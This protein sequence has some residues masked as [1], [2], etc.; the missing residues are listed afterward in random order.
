MNLV[1][2][3]EGLDRVPWG[4][5]GCVEIPAVLHALSSADADRSDE[6]VE[7]LYGLLLDQEAATAATVQVVPFIARLAAAGFRT[8]GLL[9]LLGRIAAIENE[10]DIPPGAARDAVAE[11]LPL[12]LPLLEHSD[13]EVRQ[14]AVWAVAHCRKPEASW[15]AM[16]T[17]WAV[18]REPAVRA[19]LLFGCVLLD[20][21]ATRPLV[22]EAL[23]A[24]QHD[25]VR[26]AALIAGLDAGLAWTR[27]S[28]TAAVSLLPASDRIGRTPW[29]YDPFPEIIERLLARR[30]LNNAI[31][32]ANA[33]L[34]LTGPRHADARKEG[35]WGARLIGDQHP[36]VRVRLLPAM[37]PLV[38]DPETAVVGLVTRWRK[39]DSAVDQT[40]VDFASQEDPVAADRALALLISTDAP[41]APSLLARY[42]PQRPR[43]LA[44]T[45]MSE[46]GGRIR[47]VRPMACDPTLLNAI[48]A[49][50][51]E[52]DVSE[53][54]AGHLLGLLGHWGPSARSALPELLTALPRFPLLVPGVLALV[55]ID[56]EADRAAAVEA[57]QAA[58][59]HT[60]GGPTATEAVHKLTGKGA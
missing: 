28:A 17:R 40:L 35:L 57:L 25:Q 10:V 7:E 8:S 42:L 24:D 52:V 33:A 45:S 27:Q 21:M 37:L 12:L 5:Y 11:Q 56:T 1:R 58:A 2:E 39:H 15:E 22:T 3:L 36:E 23:R 14:P 30:E 59:H 43:A 54:E 26:I 47:Y 29:L 46:A 53:E 6:A 49:R 18:E 31:D 4:R 34:N 9:Y 55:A 19:D 16:A 38:D 44:A 48:R 41:Q 32:L 60:E 51:V 13:V 20:P 50:L